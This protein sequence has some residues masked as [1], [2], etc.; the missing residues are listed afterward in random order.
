MQWLEQIPNIY[1]EDDK[2]VHPRDLGPNFYSSDAFVNKLLDYF[3]ER[4]PDDRAKPFFAYLVF[5]APHWPLQV[6]DENRNNYRGRYDEGPGVLRQGRISALKKLKIVPQEAVPHPV[7]AIPDD[8]ELYQEWED[9]SKSQQ[10]A[11]ARRM[12][13]Y[14]AMVERMDAQIGKVID[15]LKE[16]DELD[17]TLVLFISDNGAEGMLLEAVPLVGAN[18]EEHLDKYYDNSVENLG[19]YN[20]FA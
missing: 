10:A 2:A 12:E 5:T 19:R 7:L 18:F 1:V 13:I 8:L 17:N 4:S 9:L 15:Y 3:K 6:P 11:S 14:A 16:T 20:S